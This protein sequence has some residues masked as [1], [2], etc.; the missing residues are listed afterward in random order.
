MPIAL[1]MS[2]PTGSI[3]A[4]PH[5]FAFGEF[6][7]TPE[8]QSLMRLD[9]PVRIGGRA[10]DLL[11]ALVERP[12]ELLDK[13]TLMARAWPTTF[14][15]STNLKVNMASLRKALGERH[16]APQFIA[17]VVG[18]GYRFIAPVRPLSRTAAPHAG[19]GPGAGT[20]IAGLLDTLDGILRELQHLGLESLDT[21]RPFTG[22]NGQ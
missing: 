17:T 15:E 7:L 9:R 16:V 4:A 18:R 22:I 21:A 10:L 20:R 1:P 14:V 13:Q 11:T 12:G 3:T 6:V 8:R 19:T 2:V 5:A